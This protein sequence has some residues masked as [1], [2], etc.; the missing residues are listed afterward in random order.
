MH[1][2]LALV[3]AASAHAWSLAHARQV[4]ATYDYAVTDTTQADRPQYRL[5][6]SPKQAR[7]LKL[8]RGRFV[9]AG[10]GH[11]GYT[12]SDIAVRFT[13]TRT[14]TLV[15]FR[16][17]SADTSQPTL[18]IRAAFYYAWYPEAWTRD[19]VFPYTLFH[20]TLDFYSAD[21]AQIVRR[22]TDAM[23]YAHLNAGIYSWWGVHGYP[24][25][26]DRFWRFLAVART[27][28]FRWAIYYEPEGYADPSVARIRADLEH[29]RDAYAS[30]PAYLKVDGRPIVFVYGSAS[31]SCSTVQRWHDANNTVRAYIV[32]KAF[33][34]FRDCGVQP[35]A[36]HQ[37]SADH[38]EYSLAP[39]S[40]MIS[41]A[42]AEAHEHAQRLAR[43]PQRWK[44]D[45]AD[46]V[47]S[48]AKWQLVLTFNEW[49]EGTSVESAAEWASPSGYGTYLDAL[50]D[51]LP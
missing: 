46:M 28:P 25:T 1:A 6:F 8:V 24:P 38:A 35:D 36:W 4:L 50:H 45:I 39:D 14:N 17:P 16:G 10:S 42:F 33:G 30:S 21:R 26:D 34:G 44:Q 18:P 51:S 37:Y 3:L 9:F 32:Q 20:P 22:Q 47:A 15:A 19:A 13:L 41:P 49:P 11:D 2:V 5:V 27:T 40:F 31:D 29:I 12:D 23:R 7:A 43:D 48:N